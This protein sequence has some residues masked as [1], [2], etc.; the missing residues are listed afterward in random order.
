MSVDYYSCKKCGSTFPDCG[1]FERCSGDA[2]GCGRVWCCTDC[3]EK[4]EQV[5]CYCKLEKDI[6]TCDGYAEEDCELSNDGDCS[7]CENFVKASCKYCGLREYED[8]ELLY[9]ALELLKITR[10]ELIYIINNK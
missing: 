9:K 4:D 1:D 6:S 10:Q 5:E 3:S 7:E 2:G 8:D